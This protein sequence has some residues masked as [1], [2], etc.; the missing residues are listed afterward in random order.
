MTSIRNHFTQKL[1][2]LGCGLTMYS[3]YLTSPFLGPLTCVKPIVQTLSLG[4]AEKYGKQIYC[5]LQIIRFEPITSLN[6]G[7]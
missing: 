5:K 3:Q 6:L 4:K 2:P 7:D 1:K